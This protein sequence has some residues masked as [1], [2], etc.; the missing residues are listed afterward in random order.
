VR[1]GER[2]PKKQKVTKDG[3]VGAGEE[4]W[5]DVVKAGAAPSSQKNYLGKNRPGRG[6]RIAPKRG[7]EKR[8]KILRGREI[9]EICRER[10][11][12]IGKGGGVAKKNRKLSSREGR[13]MQKSVS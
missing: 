9:G 4:S 8:K 12:E 2:T 3:E 10:K 1:R 11:V 13:K 6:T 5:T 7:D